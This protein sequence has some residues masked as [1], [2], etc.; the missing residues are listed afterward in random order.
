MPDASEPHTDVP[1][2]LIAAPA[3]GQGKTLVTLGLLRAFR[4][5]GVSV[6]SAKIGPDYIDPGFHAAASGAPSVNL[7][8]W[9]MRPETLA[10]ALAL[11]GD[12]D[13]IIAEGV[14]GLFDGAAGE[15]GS[16]AD[17]AERFGLPV[18][19]VVDAGAQGPSAAAVVRG[20]HRHRD[21]LSIAGVIFNRIGSGRHASLVKDAMTRRLPGVPVLGCVPRDAGLETPS[22]HLGLVQA[23]E[24]GD[25]ETFIERASE[26]M[27][28]HLRLDALRALAAPVSTPPPVEPSPAIP[29][30]GQR[31]A[32][33]EDDAFSFTYRHLLEGWRRA[34]AELAPFSPLADEAPDETADAVYLPGGYPELHAGRL[35]GNRRFLDGLRRGAEAG[36]AIFGECGGY[37]VLGDVLTDAG[38]VE[39]AMAGLLPVETSFA[40]RRLRL[41]YRL[42]ALLTDSPLGPR[43]AQFRGHEFHYA[44]VIRETGAAPL[45]DVEAADGGSREAAGLARGSV[46]GSFIHLIDLVS[47]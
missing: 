20:F 8:L 47:D 30:L 44:K 46:A 10:G 22:R 13:L 41:G 11:Q 15:T 45:F 39:H 5:Q 17:A 14:M 40:G 34:G 1:G 16:S 43:G 32:V 35:A 21:G 29:P 28:A 31:I 25:L 27:T 33:A 24:R 12:A 9:A 2:L 23:R 19:L 42:A 3:S 38:G 6:R 37:M 18:I 36:T 7:D 4:K 26:L